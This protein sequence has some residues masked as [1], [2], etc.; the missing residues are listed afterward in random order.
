MSKV[1][2]SALRLHVV[3]KF[4]YVSGIF[5]TDSIDSLKS[6]PEMVAFDPSMAAVSADRYLLDLQ[7]FRHNLK[8]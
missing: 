5:V 6:W 1:I 3:F 4:S 7:K 8:S 2:N